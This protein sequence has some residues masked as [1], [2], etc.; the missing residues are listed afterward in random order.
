M[1]D[2]REQGISIVLS[3]AQVEILASAFLVQ[4]PTAFAEREILQIGL[5]FGLAWISL[6]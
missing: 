1:S 4:I 5:Q 2:I 3:A 6:W